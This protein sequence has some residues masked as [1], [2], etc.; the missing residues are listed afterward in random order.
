MPTPSQLPLPPRR[1]FVQRL[2]SLSAVFAVGAA[3]SRLLG[4]ETQGAAVDP[5]LSGVK[6]KH[7]QVFDAPE[8]NNGFPSIFAATYLGTMTATYKLTPGQAH[9]VVVLRHF[10]MPL[11]LTDAIWAKYKLGAMINVVDPVTKAP[12]MRN[13]YYMPKDGDMMF[14]TASIDNVM[15]M[16]STFLVCGA[17]LAV[18]SEKAGAA[19]GVDAAT[20]KKEWEAG[21]IPGMHVVPSGV[22]A[23]GRAQEIG[24]SYCFAG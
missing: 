2:A 3:P 17:A 14:P 7:K 10:A 21:L 23:V 18:L 13:L 19:I 12:S 9:A 5:W 15:K 24:C 22:L 6:G 1:S 8:P 4:A 20:A 16:S 11:A